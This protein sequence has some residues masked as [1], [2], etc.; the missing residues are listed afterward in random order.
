MC[1]GILAGLVAITGGCDNFDLWGAFVFAFVGGIIYIL[2]SKAWAKMGIDDPL[3]ASPLHG[4]V[5]L[6][7][8]I[9]VGLIDKDRGGFY[10]HGGYLFG[11]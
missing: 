1:N 4:S 7:G 10:G 2:G 6:F 3:D 8:A 9:S 11:V 5:G